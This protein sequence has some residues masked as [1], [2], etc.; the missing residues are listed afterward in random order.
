MEH[1]GTMTRV[2]LKDT[3]QSFKNLSYNE[4]YRRMCAAGEWAMDNC[5]GSHYGVQEM[6]DVGSAGCDWMGEFVFT[7]EKDAAFFK[8]KWQ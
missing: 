3:D 4:A 6:S 2:Y 1:T 7:N 8:L 5:V